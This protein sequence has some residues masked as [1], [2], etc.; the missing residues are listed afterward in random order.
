V[1]A[2]VLLDIAVRS[3]EMMYST[4]REQAAIQH[5]DLGVE[6][7]GNVLNLLHRSNCMWS[8]IWKSHMD[9]LVR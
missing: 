2:L 1:Q 9:L 6:F 5:S 4:T 3:I 7:A 8:W